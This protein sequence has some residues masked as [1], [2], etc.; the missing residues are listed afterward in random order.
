MTTAYHPQADG[1]SERTN[2]TIEA[3]LRILVLEF[4]TKA[5]VDLLPTIE[6]AHKLTPHFVTGKSPFELLYAMAPRSFGDVNL[7]IPT[8]SMAVQD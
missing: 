6:I 7:P 8:H 1:Q 5:W 4:D 2:R 3:M